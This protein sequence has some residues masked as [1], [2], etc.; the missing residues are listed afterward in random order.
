ME[1]F[2]QSERAISRRIL[3]GLADAEGIVRQV[4]PGGESSQQS[5]VASFECVK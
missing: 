4:E 5:G 1:W 2:T 3:V